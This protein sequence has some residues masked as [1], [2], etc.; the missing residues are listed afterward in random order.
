MSSLDALFSLVQRLS[1]RGWRELLRK[2]G[3]DIAMPTS[4]ALAQE[5]AR[6]IALTIDRTVPGF[7]DFARP[8]SATEPVRAIEPGKPFRSLL[9][10]AL[11]S[12]RVRLRENDEAAYATLTELDVVENYIYAA[13]NTSLQSLKDECKSRWPAATLAIA[14]FAYEYRVS[15]ESVHGRFADLTFSRTGVARVGTADAKFLSSKRGFVDREPADQK[16]SVR[17]LGCRYAAFVAVGLGR[18]DAAPFTLPTLNVEDPSGPP[19]PVF[20]LPIHKL[21][22]GDD[23]LSDLPGLDLEVSLRHRNEKL[24]RIH[25]YLRSRGV[26]TGKTP[27]DAPPF[28]ETAAIATGSRHGSSACV[29]P[30]PGP[31]AAPV[32]FQQ[33]PFTI[34]V[35]HVPRKRGEGPVTMLASSLEI[36]AAADDSRHAPEYMHARTRIASTGSLDLNLEADVAGAVA[37]GGYEAQHYRDGTGDGFVRFFMKAP[38]AAASLPTLAAYSLV[39]AVDFFPRTRQY[40]L[41][42]WAAN[43]QP[44]TLR[45]RIWNRPPDSLS[46]QRLPPNLTLLDEGGAA[47]FSDADGSATAVVCSP[48]DSPAF[49]S[50]S[51]GGFASHSFLPDNA[52][53]YFAPGWDTSVDTTLGRKHLAAYGLGSPFPEDA[54][55]C[56]AISSFWPAAAPDIARKYTPNPHWPSISPLT[57]EELFGLDALD[58]E[59]AAPTVSPSGDRI[60]YSSFDHADW[61]RV[62][63]KGAFVFE[64]LSV[65]D[66]EEYEARTLAMAR[67]YHALGV[68]LTGP[69]ANDAVN[70]HKAK[71]ALLSFRRVGPT[72]PATLL[73]TLAGI[74]VVPMPDGY[75]LDVAQWGPTL[76][77]GHQDTVAAV[78]GTRLL[79]FTI[80][81]AAADGTPHPIWLRRSGS[82][83]SAM[84]PF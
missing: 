74:G 75:L 80:R 55:L 8:L 26:N 10:H 25:S 32:T 58:G 57:D 31:L 50:D 3:L 20:W 29:L 27:R 42:R 73:T 35:P 53:G 19:S 83:T 49:R 54:K 40:D 5:L 52:A 21:F 76:V 6:N 77:S 2:H 59:P 61:T 60:V 68:D 56:A 14:T 33:V 9:Y 1:S 70:D 69:G 66:E 11:A 23:C 67:A 62:A 82:W 44:P 34:T 37:A 81:E 12:P 64:R 45:K 78:V 71:F 22:A 43:L 65:V 39:T 48:E 24:F 28:V 30:S 41:A 38:G 13:R 7:E 17:A 46:G 84:V 72:S 4:E 15:G 79:I 47:V 51:F 16:T 18:R 63:H 36:T